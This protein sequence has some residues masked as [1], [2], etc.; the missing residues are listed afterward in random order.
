[1]CP[2][3]V[4]LKRGLWSIGI[5]SALTVLGAVPTLVLASRV[6][7]SADFVTT[8]ALTQTNPGT[9]VHSLSF[10]DTNGDG[11]PDDLNSNGTPGEPG[12]VPAGDQTMRIDR[13]GQVFEGT[14]DEVTALTEKGK[15]VAKQ[16]T[17]ANLTITFNSTIFVGPAIAPGVH[18]IFGAASGE[19][20]ITRQDHNEDA[21]EKEA[22]RESLTIGFR[23][24]LEG[25]L[26]TQG[27]LDPGDDT[28]VVSDTGH[29]KVIK[30]Q[31]GLNSLKKLKG[32]L[33]APATGPVG[34]ESAVVKLSGLVK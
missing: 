12:L 8:I 17:G 13:P 30:A 34:A 18:A 22:E 15:K 21:H 6:G 33:S 5:L 2:R 19:V 27:T 1:M 11:L 24:D 4:N 20:L 28:V 32:D 3:L 10:V 7:D 16:V 26:N 23:A 9:P 31:G 25:T 29:F 14:I